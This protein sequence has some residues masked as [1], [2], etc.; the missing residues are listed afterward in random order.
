MTELFERMPLMNIV[1]MILF[2]GSY[3]MLTVTSITHPY[4]QPMAL[5]PPVF[6]FVHILLTIF[7]EYNVMH[8]NK[9]FWAM[10][11]TISTVIDGPIP[12]KAG[13]VKYIIATKNRYV[14][15][16][17]KKYM[18]GFQ[19]FKA[20]IR[21]SAI[22]EIV[23]PVEQFMPVAEEDTN[24]PDGAIVYLRG[25]DGKKVTNINSF[26]QRR[27]EHAETM[28]CINEAIYEQMKG[29][30]SNMAQSS[31]NEV[32]LAAQKISTILK[33]IQNAQQPAYVHPMMMQNQQKYER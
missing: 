29:L 12:V 2:M 5:L 1:S 30:A 27:L 31:N 9:N 17:M 15:K 24:G 11:G 19:G 18:S 23:A 25:L 4:F 26:L 32:L 6:L 13:E 3:V 28:N 33:D 20:L 10:D 22:M 14:P 7:G 16:S 21:G 8:Y